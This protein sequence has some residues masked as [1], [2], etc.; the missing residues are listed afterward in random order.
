VVISDIDS[1]DH[2]QGRLF[3]LDN[4]E[5][6]GGA[7]K[8]LLRDRV[9]EFD[10]QEETQGEARMISDD[11]DESAS[12]K[13]DPPDAPK[14]IG[15]LN[16]RNVSPVI[17]HILR[18]AGSTALEHKRS[19]DSTI[20]LATI[21]VCSVDRDPNDIGYALCNSLREQDTSLIAENSTKEEVALQLLQ[22]HRINRFSERFED[23]QIESVPFEG[24]VEAIIRVALEFSLEANADQHLQPRHVLGTMLSPG[25]ASLPT[26]QS[27]L[28]EMGVNIERIRKD[29]RDFIRTQDREKLSTWEYRLFA[30]PP[31]V[32][33][34]SVVPA[35]VSDQP[36]KKDSLGFKPYVRAVA[37]FLSTE[38]TVPPLTLS[39]EGA[40]GSGKSSF[41]LQLETKLKS[42]A[43]ASGQ[44]CLTV[45]FNAWRHDKEDALWASF[46]LEF[47][48][49]LAR[50]LPLHSRF[51]AYLKL[52]AIRFRWRDGWVALLR[53]LVLL[54]IFLFISGVLASLLYSKGI[55]SIVSSPST[56]RDQTSTDNSTVPA[57]GKEK[58]EL[59][60]DRIFVGL[61]KG[62]GIVGYFAILL[63]L[64]TKLKDY[65]G[66]PFSVNFAQYVYSPD[67]KGRVA[68]IENFH[69]D[70]IK[71][72]HT[73]AG[74]N[75]VYVFIDDL[76]R[77]EV[78]KAADLMQALN[79][80]ISDSPQLIFIIGMDREKVAAGLAVKYE[81]LLPYLSPSR[82]AQSMN[83]DGI[84][85]KR[86]S[87]LPV[88]NES[89]NL[90]FDPWGGMEYGY[91]FIE[92]F[93][94][95]PFRVPQPEE[96]ELRRLLNE[97]SPPIKTT[98][99]AVKNAEG[100]IGADSNST[101]NKGGRASYIVSD[102][103]KSE[104]GHEVSKT[105]ASNPDAPTPEHI[106]RKERFKLNAIGDLSDSDTIRN[107]VMMVAPAL[108]FNPRRLKQFINMFRLKAFIAAETGLNESLT[109]EQLGKLVV[110]GL[111][112]PRLLSDLEEDPELL[113]QL[114]Q[115]T[116]QP[117]L[118][119]KRDKAAVRHWIMKK[120]LLKLLEY[121]C[122]NKGGRPFN[123]SQYTLEKVDIN[124]I[125][126][127]SAGRQYQSLEVGS[128]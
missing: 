11:I 15:M 50:Q 24:E 37:E 65:L 4:D 73:Y 64:I 8:M 48:R 84:Q 29:L 97:V 81:K 88:L 118:A 47:I 121:G 93:V 19:V 103:T 30:A 57:P 42:L 114:Q 70:F 89:T 43:A 34:D 25:S 95:L 72:V 109:L 13:D 58:K 7:K 32:T 116:L 41:M 51:W 54:F 69:E 108:E 124:L 101:V 87:R 74:K 122:V 10:Q 76:D 26:V 56:G 3:L 92:K 66:N 111:K 31:D 83:Q 120:E 82:P 33:I 63:F 110:M 105:E 53:T 22:R 46:A 14:L 55:E 18:V 49:Q 85:T 115:C 27:R 102:V 71:V 12:S 60:L 21:I 86:G 126:R 40:W 45:R 17:R 20:L 90:V 107:I 16:G 39:V 35:N 61:V 123:V 80:M 106:K 119:A 23:Q 44:Q 113:T 98:A 96:P 99:N 100:D 125:L 1:K 77:C 79:L 68:F 67:Y 94:Q 78:P 75:K 38:K 59:D 28:V 91:T 36:A 104:Q 6:I 62:S 2:H 127:V 9:L 128:D 112:W 5:Q 117:D 52:V